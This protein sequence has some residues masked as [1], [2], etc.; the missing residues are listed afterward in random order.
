MR[1]WLREL[2]V[3]LLVAVVATVA[4]GAAS[5]IAILTGEPFP[6]GVPGAE[7][8]RLNSVGTI[9]GAVVDPDSTIYVLVEDPTEDQ[10]A[11]ALIAAL[12][13]YALT[14]T[15]L[16]LLW[17][18]VA[19]A[20]RTDTFTGATVRRLRTLGWLLIVGGPV[21]WLV[22]FAARFALS[23]TVA[24]QGAG[25]TLDLGTLGVW[26]LVGVGMLAISEVVHRG[27]TLQS[28]LDEVV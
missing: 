25:A 13:G 20:R 28:E 11:L 3:L 19:K 26:L 2:Q 22:E 4:I 21:A 27:Q 1:S 17:R 16:V 9:P 5:T 23:D 6:I 10:V 24:T 14:T 7:V 15:M 8:L 12:P 18:L